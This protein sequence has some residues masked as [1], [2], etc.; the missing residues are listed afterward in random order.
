M[1]DTL[2]FI[3]SAEMEG[4]QTGQLLKLQC[5][6]QTYWILGLNGDWRTLTTKEIYL[7]VLFYIRLLSE[8]ILITKYNIK[9]LNNLY[10]IQFISLLEDGG[11][12]IAFNP[13]DEAFFLIGTEEGIVYR[14]TTEY[15]TF[16]DSYVAHNVP[17]Y[18][19]CLNSVHV[20]PA[21]V[22]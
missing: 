18:N 12:C 10:N 16:L 19:I 20:T 4:Y 6:I 13:G 14:C 2:I 15:S 11:R 22:V 3:P 1:T 17:V 8:F 9:S 21:W 7:R 5:G